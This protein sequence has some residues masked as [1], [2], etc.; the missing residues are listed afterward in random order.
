MRGAASPSCQAFIG[1]FKHPKRVYWQDDM[2]SLL[3]IGDG[4]GIFKWSF[5]GDKEMPSD[6]SRCF[7]EI[8][9]KP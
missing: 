6:I 8:E 1:H 3:S 9:A 2:R 4:N 7:E 5:F